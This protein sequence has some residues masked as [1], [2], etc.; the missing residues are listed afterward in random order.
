M[1]TNSGTC[2]WQY[3]LQRLEQRIRWTVYNILRGR[4][5][6]VSIKRHRYCVCMR[7]IWS[8]VAKCAGRH[9]LP[10]YMNVAVLKH[11]CIHSLATMK[12][13]LRVRWFTCLVKCL[14]PHVLVD[15]TSIAMSAASRSND[16][17]H[18]TGSCES[19]DVRLQIGSAYIDI[20]QR[21][22]MSAM[23]TADRFIDQCVSD[24]VYILCG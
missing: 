15:R 10:R 12:Y 11:V 2:T 18:Y 7:G 13:N 17:H 22:E 21:H 9:W 1:P 4:L 23:C 3:R 6:Y 16:V 20:L 14:L 19:D 5:G 24:T 8:V